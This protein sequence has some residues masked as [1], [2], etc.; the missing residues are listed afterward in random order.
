MKPLYMWAGG[1]NK[2]IPKYLAH[3]GIPL[4]GYD[5]YSEP[6]FG[7]GAMMIWL[8]QQRVQVKHWVLNDINP[9]IVGI[10]RAIKNHHQDFVT[11]LD[12]LSAQ[13][14]PLD[15]A[16]R[17]SWFYDQR[18]QYIDPTIYGQWAP[19]EE[20]AHLYFLMKTAFN[21]IFQTTKEAKGRFCTPAGLLNQRGS[22]Y[23]KANVQAWHAFLQNV[24]VM[25][26]TWQQAS[27][28]AESLGRSFHFFDPPYRDSF[29]QYAQ[30]FTDQ[31]ALDLI[32]YCQQR[33]Q[34]GDL[35]M[36]CNRDAGD[37]FY[38]RNQG[39]LS[40]ATYNITYTAGRRATA[41]DGSKT[42]KSATEILLYSSSING[43]AQSPAPAKIKT[44]TKKTKILATEV[45]D[46]EAQ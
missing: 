25:S 30:T 20:S 24:T 33:D 44:K 3:P 5:V 34:Q 12:Q 37:D 39:Q 23:D 18:S 27:Q 38:T 2:M 14:L 13:Y 9:E 4:Q 31:D 28:C 8:Y 7:G 32:T 16:S 42:A 22:V 41:E 26:G 36:F 19:W 15:K 45:F 1:K 11:V 46:F 29:T 6:F 35:V 21:G 43:L 17:K 40:L 10:Y